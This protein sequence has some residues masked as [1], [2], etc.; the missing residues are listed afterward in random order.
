MSVGA[1]FVTSEDL[2]ED[3]IAAEWLVAVKEMK[4][5]KK[6]SNHDPE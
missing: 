3:K 5:R 4:A 2:D 6:E 1:S